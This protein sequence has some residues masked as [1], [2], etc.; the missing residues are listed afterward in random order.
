MIQK[1]NVHTIAFDADDTLWVNET[2]FREAEDAFCQ[3]LADY[4]SPANVKKRLFKIE[5]DNL[6]YYGYGIKSFVLSMVDCIYDYAGDDAPS[7]LVK[8]AVSIGRHML[9]KPVELLDGVVEVLEKLHG[10]YHLIV[11]T[12]GDLLDQE[13][14]LQLSG[15]ETHFDFVEV[16]SNKKV[17]NYEKLLR[18]INCTAERFVMIGNSLRSDIQPVLDIGGS[19]IHVP[20]HTTWEH[21]LIAHEIKHDRFM[22]CGDIR[23]ILPLF[24]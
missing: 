23:E 5:I 8:E 9:A 11:A 14:K 7:H 16:M 3:L 1:E 15:I 20:F 22:E 19:A 18:K 12:K 17:A 4:D 21:E 13:R 10:K 24:E 6:A 2:F